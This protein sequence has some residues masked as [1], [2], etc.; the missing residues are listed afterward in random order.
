MDAVVSFW[1][2]GQPATAGNKTGFPVRG[3][4]GRTHVAMREGRT[5]RSAAHAKAWRATVAMAAQ[6]A[7][8]RA[9]LLPLCGPLRLVAYF[10]RVRPSNHYRANGQLRPR[11]PRWPT[12]RPD[13]TKLLRALED[14]A[15]GICWGDDA[16]IVQHMTTKL[17]GHTPGVALAVAST[18]AGGLGEVNAAAHAVLDRVTDARRRQDDEVVAD[19]VGGGGDGAGDRGSGRVCRARSL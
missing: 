12:T 5:P 9:R 8:V 16:Q 18:E 4:D 2:P 19:G 6:D 11:A 3:K 17:Y 1:A 7:M 10:V 15:T 13:S 14:A